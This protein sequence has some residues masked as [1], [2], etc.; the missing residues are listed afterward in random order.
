MWCQEINLK[1]K[2]LV[3]NFRE[4]DGAHASVYIGRDTVERTS[5]AG[6]L[7]VTLSSNHSPHQLLPMR[8]GVRRHGVHYILVGQKFCKQKLQR[9]SQTIIGMPLPSM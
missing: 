6:F 8:Y 9:M 5:S 4:Q 1:N 3:M 2:K 7:G